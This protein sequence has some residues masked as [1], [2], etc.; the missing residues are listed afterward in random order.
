MDSA[1][2]QVKDLESACVRVRGIIALHHG[3]RDQLVP[4]TE[5]CMTLSRETMHQLLQTLQEVETLVV[6]TN[7]RLEAVEDIMLST[8]CDTLNDPSY[9]AA[10]TLVTS[11]KKREH[12]E[13]AMLERETGTGPGRKMRGVF[14]HALE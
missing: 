6:K 7:E 10:S 9:Q 13:L 3:K 1:R 8:L 11:T 5:K 14:V 12:D 2:K 4:K